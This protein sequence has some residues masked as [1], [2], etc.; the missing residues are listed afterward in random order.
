MNSARYLPTDFWV[1]I[2]R[3]FV[4]NYRQILSTNFSVGNYR[5]IYR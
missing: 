3:F 4:D 2:D 5:H 1:I